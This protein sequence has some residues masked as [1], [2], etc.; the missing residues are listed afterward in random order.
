MQRLDLLRTEP[1]NLEHLQQARRDG[2]LEF[3]VIGQLSGRCEFG[4]LFLQRLAD[5]LDLAQ[6][7]L[8]D[9]FVER[10]VQGFERARRIGIGARLER[11][12]ALEF[13]QHANLGEHSGD[14]VF[15]HRR[16]YAADAGKCKVEN[17]P[18]YSGWNWTKVGK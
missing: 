18:S 14:L 2:R 12:L 17:G 3:L 15:V 1:G 4:D 7:V 11:V 13:E 8:R 9:D 10:L 6:P 5:A 16:K